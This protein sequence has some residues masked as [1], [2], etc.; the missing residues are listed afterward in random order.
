[1]AASDAH[2]VMT[3]QEAEQLGTYCPHFF[4]VYDFVRNIAERH[5]CRDIGTPNEWGTMVFL[6]TIY[7]AGRV[8]G[9]R[10]ERTKRKSNRPARPL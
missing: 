6:S 3:V 1:M 10:A 9:I 5:G 2:T 4:A 8:D 7:N